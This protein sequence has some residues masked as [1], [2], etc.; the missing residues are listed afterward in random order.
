[1]TK[2]QLVTQLCL[3]LITEM[4]YVISNYGLRNPKPG[5]GV[6]KEKEGGIFTILCICRHCLSPFCKV[7]YSYDDVTMPPS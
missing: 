4:R 7:I 1:M 3:H 5:Y 6:I 2:T